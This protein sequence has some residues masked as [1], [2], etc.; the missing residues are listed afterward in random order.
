MRS[1][2]LQI[3]QILFLV[4]MNVDQVDAHKHAIKDEPISSHLESTSLVKK[5]LLL[6]KNNL[7]NFLWDTAS[8]RYPKQAVYMYYLIAYLGS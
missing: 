3:G 7:N 2:R 4:F 8:Y 6:S 1:T 5:D